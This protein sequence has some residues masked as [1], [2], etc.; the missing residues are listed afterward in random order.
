MQVVT[1]RDSILDCGRY[2]EHGVTRDQLLVR[3]DDRLFPEFLGHDLQS[4][5]PAALEHRAR[6]GATVRGLPS[7]ASWL[8]VH[9]DAVALLTVGGND[10]LQGLVDDDAP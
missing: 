6:D 2:N 5:R 10:L 9:G 8:Q 1:F 4:R 7:Q 3:N